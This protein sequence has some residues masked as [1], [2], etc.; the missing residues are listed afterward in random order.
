MEFLNVFIQ[1]ISVQCVLDG[2]TV[3]NAED[4][5]KKRIRQ[6]FPDIKELMFQWQ[7]CSM[8]NESEPNRSRI[9]NN[10]SKR[11]NAAENNMK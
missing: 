7:R 5:A 6:K 11:E 3:L 2:N 1:Q 9:P 10:K 8:I 4:T